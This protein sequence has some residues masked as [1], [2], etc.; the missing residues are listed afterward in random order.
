MSPS[1]VFK[2]IVWLVLGAAVLC[3]ATWSLGLAE[4]GQ[5]SKEKLPPESP[6]QRDPAA[7]PVTTEPIVYRAVQRSIAAVGTLHPF[8]EV[9]ISA[10]VEGQVRRI[11]H[12]VG[13]RVAPGELLLEIDRTDQQLK[14][15]EAQRALEVEMSKLGLT[16]TP[17]EEFDVT[18]VPSV[19]QASVRLKRASERVERAQELADRNVLAA[20]ELSNLLSERGV[21]QAEYD[22]QVLVANTGLA[23]VRWKQELL[24]MAERNLAETEIRAPQPSGLQPP[25][26]GP[27]Q[28]AVTARSAAEGNFLRVG[29]EVFRLVLDRTLK[30]KVVVPD[31]HVADV[32]EGQQVA[33]RTSAYDQ[34]FAGVVKRINPAVDRETRTFEVEI[35]VDNADGQLKA[36]SFAKAL[37]QTNVSPA[38]ATVPV[39]ALVRFAGIT[40][41]F[42][43][44]EQAAREV[45]VTTGV[46]Q[47]Q[48]VEVVS[49]DLPQDAHVITS[50]QTLL[51]DRTP[52]FV[53][54]PP[55]TAHAKPAAPARR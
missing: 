10:K 18:H 42:V 43:A 31:V 5:R 9:A 13:D 24:T 51:A 8:E 2:Q 19:V 14:V 1:R 25:S 37:I 46:V 15:R 54:T 48:W 41:V 27:L 23:T 20:D 55:A 47:D 22:H 11:L 29:T 44:E 50:G 12:D 17:G 40:K 49:A 7:V 39:E 53:R 30:L 21:A 52:I 45:P 33:V 32:R 35:H 26:A 28:F 38:A 3:G 16:E 4:F 36:G 6:E 34:S